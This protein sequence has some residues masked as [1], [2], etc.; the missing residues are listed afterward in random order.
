MNR[1]ILNIS[2]VILYILGLVCMAFSQ[3]KITNN[4][5]LSFL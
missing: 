3:E 1:R 5:E 2:G 4:F